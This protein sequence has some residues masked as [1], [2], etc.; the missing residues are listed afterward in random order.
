MKLTTRQLRQIIREEV[1]AATKRKLLKEALGPY[2]LVLA[3]LKILM[4]PDATPGTMIQ[5]AGEVTEF[6]AQLPDEDQAELKELSNEELEKKLKDMS[7]K[8]EQQA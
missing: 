8:W 4:D 5:A 6:M 3:A 7:K 2:G 1:Q